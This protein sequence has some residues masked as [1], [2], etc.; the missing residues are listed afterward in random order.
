MKPNST[1]KRNLK[2]T[3]QMKLNWKQNWELNMLLKEENNMALEN[4]LK[5]EITRKLKWNFYLLLM[6]TRNGRSK[7]GS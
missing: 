7:I 4:E 6:S 5:K 3:L 1:L 2:M